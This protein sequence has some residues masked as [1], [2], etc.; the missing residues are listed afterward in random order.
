MKPFFQVLIVAQILLFSHSVTAQNSW[1]KKYTL[2]SDTSYF[3]S[4]THSLTIGETT[5]TY[6]TYSKPNQTIEVKIYPKDP[7]MSMNLLPSRDFILIDSMVKFSDYSRFKIQFENLNR[8]ELLRFTLKFKLDT[9]YVFEEFHLQPISTTRAEIR[10]T[11]NQLFIGELKTYE[12]FSN[13]PEN[14]NITPEW[15]NTEFMDYQFSLSGGKIYL[16]II[17]QKLG[18]Q[19]LSASLSTINPSLSIDNKPNYFIRPIEHSFTVKASRLQFLGLD[20]SEI[21]LDSKNQMNGTEIQIENSRLLRMHKTY[22]IEAQEES[23]G[24]L[25]AELYT[26]QALANNKVLCIL[27]PYNFHRSS[28]GYLYIK[29]GDS[30]KFISNLTIS[31]STHIENIYILSEGKNWKKGNTVHPGESFDIKIVGE[32]LHKAKFY[33]EG[34]SNIGL[35]T[36]IKSEKE[37]YFRLQVPE[38]ISKKSINIYNHNEPTGKTLTIKEYQTPRE[39]DYIYMSYG[40]M[41]RRVN[42]INAP[43]LYN[44]VVKDVVFSFKTNKI[45]ENKLYGKQYLK[46]H[47]SITGEKDELIELKTIDNITLCPSDKSPRGNY[48]D[49]KNCYT[50][51]LNLNKYLRKSTYDLDDWSTITIKLEH[52][53]SKYGGLGFS[54][55]LDIILKRSYSFDLEVS[56]PAGLLT[57][58]PSDTSNSIGSL[59]GISMAMIG[60]FSFYHP[61]KINTYRP[62]KIG[63]GFLALNA[64]NF[65]DDDD[66]ERDVGFVIL[67]SLYPTSKNSKLSF[68]L[69]IGG[70]YFI[71]E[72]TFVFLVGPG[73]KVE[74]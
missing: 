70:G 57:V 24:S 59:S 39:F 48:Y 73:I 1:V 5:K 12:V 56:F 21:S 58:S 64:F 6:F 46:M 49:L 51:E 15:V 35:D 37:Q 72:K 36:L 29:D 38:D 66:A 50:G 10:P 54:K 41:G 2:A 45:D 52:D 4:D 71:H 11:D 44:D 9:G 61:D 33:F 22:R 43:I 34:L 14:L 68:P 53:K 20:Q 55:E 31:P 60:Q 67:G 7:M 16:S 42:G 63:A 47:I 8:T 23:G 17:P 27:R 32:G 69:Y 3:N 62:F 74:F 65:S 18:L 40:D 13:N 26:K 25:I 19:A 30:P 28:A